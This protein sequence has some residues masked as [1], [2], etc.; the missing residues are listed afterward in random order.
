MH[1]AARGSSSLRVSENMKPRDNLGILD[2][3]GS[4]IRY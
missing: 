1:I 3:D 4:L 2:V